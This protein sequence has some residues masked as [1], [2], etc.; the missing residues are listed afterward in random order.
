M[1][2]IYFTEEVSRFERSTETRDEQSANMKYVL[3]AEDVSSPE[4]STDFM[5]EQFEN[6]NCTPIAETEPLNAANET[7]S[8]YSNHER[9]RRVNGPLAGVGGSLSD[10]NGG[11]D[12]ELLEGKRRWAKP[13]RV[14]RTTSAA[15]R[16][17]R[18]TVEMMRS[19]ARPFP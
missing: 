10:V 1:L 15:K 13:T 3:V 4:R 11:W 9:A 19:T 12:G 14:R 5:R 6:R 8:L 7:L 18:L 16:D 17:S 2:L